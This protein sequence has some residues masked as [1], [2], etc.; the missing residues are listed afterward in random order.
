MPS[1]DRRSRFLLRRVF[2]ILRRR[3][4]VRPEANR[5]GLATL[6]GSLADWEELPEVVK[7]IYSSRQR[8]HDRPAPTLD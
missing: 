7:E 5:V 2:A 4:P 6:A 3:L 8:A 1:D